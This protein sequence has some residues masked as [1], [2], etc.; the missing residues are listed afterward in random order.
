[1]NP[2]NEIRKITSF[3][4]A[5]LLLVILATLIPSG[6]NHQGKRI[7]GKDIR[8]VADLVLPLQE[9]KYHI[10]LT[11]LGAIAGAGI[12]VY[13]KISLGYER[14]HQH[15]AELFING[16]SRNVFYVLSFINAP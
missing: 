10:S 3:W 2:L 6:G 11:L 14:E 16:F 1:M 15:V 8:A 13:S 7:G 4:S 12:P 5:A 9:A